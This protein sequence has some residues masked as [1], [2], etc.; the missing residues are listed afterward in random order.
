MMNKVTPISRK[1]VPEIFALNISGQCW[2][3]KRIPT[4]N[5]KIPRV[6]KINEVTL[7]RFISFIFKVIAW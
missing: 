3:L 1:V 5:I 6:I 4:T 2:I 7:S